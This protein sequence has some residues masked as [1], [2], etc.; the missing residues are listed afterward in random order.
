MKTTALS[1]VHVYEW[2]HYADDKL[3]ERLKQQPHLS[4]ETMMAIMS[5]LSRINTK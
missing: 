5:L 4:H 3:F 2:K 1:R